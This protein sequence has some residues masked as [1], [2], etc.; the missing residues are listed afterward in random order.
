MTRRDFVSDN[1]TDNKPKLAVVQSPDDKTDK[2]KKAARQKNTNK[3]NTKKQTTKKPAQKKSQPKK[4]QIPQQQPKLVPQPSNEEAAIARPVVVKLQRPKSGRKINFKLILCI[5]LA[6][7]VVAAIIYFVK[8][9]KISFVND[10]DNL[11]S[12]EFGV[13]SKADFYVL[14]KNIFYC[15]KDIATLLNKDGTPQWSDT[16][17]MVSPAMLA[18]DNFVG[19]ADI[20]NKVLNVY[21]ETGKVYSLETEGNITSFAINPQGATA[22]ICRD[23]TDN[24]YTVGV[25]NPQGEKVFM[26]SYVTKDGI[27]M[28]IDISDDGTKVAV[29]FINI[30]GINITSNILFYSTDKAIAQQIENSDAMF[31][32]VNCDEE[33][34]GF[35]KFL[36]DDSCVIATDKSLINIGGEDVAAYEQNWKNE[37]TNYATAIDVVGSDYIAVAYGEPLDTTDENDD[38]VKNSIYWYNAKKGNVKGSTVMEYPVSSLSSGLGTTIAELEDNTFVALKP[39]GD[40]LWSY[41]GLQSI[42]NILFYRDTQTIAVVSAAKMT[43]TEVKNGAENT[44]VDTK[45]QDENTAEEQTA[46][47]AATEEQT[48]AEQP[49][50]EQTTAEAA[51][52]AE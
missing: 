48:A 30:S 32:A 33:M 29:G 3:K 26:G 18:D 51:T 14:N 41:K 25:Y 46:N 2:K 13:N 47:E 42:S 43:L 31:A 52:T 1:N 9:K 12:T 22:V 7:V 40:E 36:D 38:I 27:P 49:T 37:F 10:S 39:N 45:T 4:Q 44:E 16:L 8:S 23:S 6:L 50:E 34:V 28:T 11:Y 15:T 17:S 24:D 20:K 21:S 5:V 35:I 19:I